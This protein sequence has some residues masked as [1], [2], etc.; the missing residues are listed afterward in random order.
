MEEGRNGEMNI[1]EESQQVLISSI[2]QGTEK[3]NGRPKEGL[4]S[5][6]VTLAKGLQHKEHSNDADDHGDY[7]ILGESL[8]EED[9]GYKS[10]EDGGSILQKSHSAEGEQFNSVV[11]Q[12]VVDSPS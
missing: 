9:K 5:I 6:G 4:R 10:R 7:F 11:E 2:N 12:E 8:F 1:L 3:H